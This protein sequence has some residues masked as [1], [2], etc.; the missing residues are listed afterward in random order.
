MS[1]TGGGSIY[2]FEEDRG[3]NY[4][5]LWNNSAT[6]N[7]GDV[8]YYGS[9]QTA[10][11]A[12][13]A[14][15]ANVLPTTQN[16]GWSRLAQ[17]GTDGDPG[18]AGDYTIL[19]FA[20]SANEPR[21][22]NSS[23]ATY[24]ADAARF[25]STVWSRFTIPS[26]TDPVWMSWLRVE[27]ATTSLAFGEVLRLSGEDGT[28][29]KG[30]PGDSISAQYSPDGTTDW[31]S[32][33]RA[34]DKYVRF[35]IGTGSWSIANKFAG[36]DGA[37]AQIQYSPDGSTDWVNTGRGTDEYIRFRVGT[38]PW[39]IAYKI[40]GD[41][42]QSISFQFS[43]DNS[44]WHS[45]NPRSND[46]YIR[47]QQGTNT[48]TAGIKFVGDDGSDGDDS[49]ETR[50]SVGPSTTLHTTFQPGD[51]YIHFRIGN[52]GAFGPGIK[53]V[54]DDG[55][56]APHVMV[57]F[58]SQPVASR[59]GA[60]VAG[61][62]YIRFSSDGGTTWI[63]SANGVRFVGEAGQSVTGEGISFEFSQDGQAGWHAALAADDYFIRLQQGSRGWQRAVQFRAYPLQIQYSIDGSTL[64]HSTF[65]QGTDKYIRFSNDN[66][67]TWTAGDR[68]VGEDGTD[69]A[70]QLMLQY[71][72]DNSSWHAALATNDLYIR[73]STDGGATWSTGT[74]FVGVTGGFQATL[75][76]RSV[77]QPAAPTNVTYN[78]TT[79]GN[80]YGGTIGNWVPTIPTGT[81]Q[82]WRVN[83]T[84]PA[85]TT[86]G[87]LP[88]SVN[89]PVY[90][91]RGAAG[92]DG[93][94]GRWYRPVFQWATSE[95]SDPSG[96]S[97]NVP[98][99][100]IGGLGQWREAPAQQG[101]G[102]ENLWVA[103]VRISG[104]TATYILKFEYPSI[105][106]PSGSQGNSVAVI[107][108]RSAAIPTAPTGGTW[109]GSD[110]DP[111]A[112]W[113]ESVPSGDDPVYMVVVLLS[114][115]N[116][117]NTGITYGSV[118][119]ITGEDA[120]GL[121][122]TVT[123][124]NFSF[125]ADQSDRVITS[126]RPNSQ[127]TTPWPETY[128]NILAFTG[129]TSGFATHDSTGITIAESGIYSILL[130]I[131][132]RFVSGTASSPNFGI[133][134]RIEDD[135][136]TLIDNYNAFAWND[137]F[138]NYDYAAFCTTPLLNLAANT[139]IYPQIFFDP[140]R[141]T[142]PTSFGTNVTLNARI[143]NVN[144][145]NNRLVIRRY[146]N[147][148][149]GGSGT[150]G[151]SID[152]VYRR[153]STA[154]TVP[155]TGGTALNGEIRTAPQ[156]WST[157]IP[158][159]SD[160]IYTVIAHIDGGTNTIRYDEPIRW[161]G[162]DGTDGTSADPVQFQYSDNG[163][164]GW[165]AYGANSAYFRT[166]TDGGTA[167][168][169]A[170]RFKGEDG[171]DGTN[172]PGVGTQ[173]TEAR[174]TVTADATNQTLT[175]TRPDNNDGTEFVAA[176]RDVKTFTGGVAGLATQ[177]SNGINIIEA[178]AY[179]FVL[180][181]A[182]MPFNSISVIAELAATLKIEQSDGTFID[183][184][185]TA[186]YPRFSIA[187]STVHLFSFSTPIMHL[188]AGAHVYFT[189][190][191][192]DIRTGA[193]V[194][195]TYSLLYRIVNPAGADTRL[196]V[197]RYATAPGGG[198]SGGG[199]AGTAGSSI[200][201]VYRRSSTALTVPP[202]GGTASD[203]EL[204]AAPTDWSTS[205]PS[206]SDPIYTA[207]AH[208]D[209][210]NNSI[211]YDEPIRW[212][213][214]D[215]AA[216]DPVQFQYSDNNNGPWS[217]Y[218]SSNV[219]FRTSANGGTTWSSAV[220]FRG[221]TGTAAPQVQIQYSV[222][223]TSG[224]ATSVTNPYFIR[225]SVDNGS[226][227]SSPQ[228]FRQDGQRGSNADNVQIQYSVDGTS[229][230]AAAVT[231]P[232]FIRFSVDGGTTWSAAQRF[233]MDGSAGATGLSYQQFYHANTANTVGAP[234]IDYNG[235]TFTTVT[236]GWSET[237]PT[238]PTGA[239]IFM[240]PV[241]YREGTSGETIEGVLLYGT[242][243]G[244][245]TPPPSGAQTYSSGIEYGIA[246]GNTPSSTFR[247]SSAFSLSVGQSHT[248]QALDFQA[249]T[250]TNNNYFIRLPAGL[251]LTGARE[252]TLGDETSSWNRVGSTQIWIW[253]IGFAR[254]EN[255]FAFTVRR[256]S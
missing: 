96:L 188:P 71:S 131:D 136:G 138:A 241:Q 179:S 129:P 166:S 181:T 174:F 168:S 37:S 120:P 249:T 141:R 89:G 24:P 107:Y 198:T 159:G 9:P 163:T 251:T 76:Q 94:D 246:A 63:P 121:G 84:V 248:T 67:S 8:V 173:I 102:N 5:G 27:I 73:F 215:G 171:T 186:D 78:Q 45:G 44:V 130:Q 236:A 42:G 17:R 242:V 95:P 110:F 143:V 125:V 20:R 56:D 7:D 165:G 64:W 47:F 201:V 35:R 177:D 58:S 231:N 203:G 230:W 142:L 18:R 108:R 211:S 149:G 214:E 151:S 250:T 119:R 152:V 135:S 183:D 234:N 57:Q 182:I 118:V 156:D 169:N 12:N 72:I 137:P 10:Y 209:G 132:F 91:E 206:G 87:N 226:T 26:G 59:F 175:T 255:V 81:D 144:D 210:S 254:A 88:V 217:T 140:G 101:S 204:T 79:L 240:A 85:A 194:G 75:Y 153:S 117:T 83:V 244:T 11:L 212:Q 145:N 157:S 23:D 233:R 98:N 65:V 238:T 222:T 90:S 139:K 158:S 51:K 33:L 235:T 16:S 14:I 39:S 220:R 13:A 54:G 128:S 195:T 256:D 6:Y 221:V 106:G 22:P 92:A 193:G 25:S 99:G 15:A 122:T 196:A 216:A 36:D 126:T 38:M 133:L 184:F 41:D 52:T 160:P 205:V 112:G 62:Q 34:T 69:G 247:N 239:N 192:K 43:P 109:N 162:R 245:V 32:T 224:W 77:N 202:T 154:L 200:D 97:Y 155:P 189:L 213:G 253:P 180:Q 31:S 197:R 114:G 223:G 55:A 219:Y 227:W 228:R 46:K 49:L 146:T 2:I 172:P 176:T 100:T 111:P 124:A 167:W 225:F 150:A 134:L 70:D 30:D 190:S 116:R 164:G 68:F 1:I 4:R 232:Y 113:H 178:G 147:G 104:S 29:T 61:D 50:Y 93:D 161:Q 187:S 127:P 185:V 66:G 199:A 229:G 170:V 21:R 191:F 82:I 86:T 208:I 48:P 19:L 105:A 115:T 252:T 207:I 60:F 28:G 123:E 218:S 3:F 40:H 80:P 237:I 243:P 74:R 148:S 53:F 103:I